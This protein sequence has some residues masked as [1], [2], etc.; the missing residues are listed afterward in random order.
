MHGIYG[1]GVI[2]THYLLHF[3]VR[4]AP[5]CCKSFHVVPVPL[6]SL[7][8]EFTHPLVLLV[9][10]YNVHNGQSMMLRP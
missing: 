3:C 4:I 7:Q 5:F 1:N 2:V 9:L 6:L 10:L 8:Q